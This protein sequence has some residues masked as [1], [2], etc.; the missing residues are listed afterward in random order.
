MKD[1]FLATLSHELRTPLNAILGWTQI[2]RRQS[3]KTADVE[4]GMEAIDRNARA[5]VMLIDELLDLSRII[6]GRIRLDMQRIRMSEVVHGA[7]ES[8]EPTAHTKGIR[9]ERGV[10]PVAAPVSGDPTR[11]QQVAWNL[12][13][14][15]IKFTPAGGTVRI[16]LKQVGS[17]VRL[18]V[19][20]TGIGISADFLPHVFDRFSQKDSSSTRTHGGLGL[21]LAISKQLVELHGGTL[22]AHS[23]GEGHGATFTVTLPRAALSEYNEPPWLQPSHA[24]IADPQGAL[25]SIEGARALV[26]DDEDDARDLVQRVLEE[27]GAIVTTTSS[28]EEAWALLAAI[29][30][31]IILCDIGM[32]GMDG[33]QLMRRIR[34][35]AGKSRRIPALALTAFARP[36][37]RKKAILAGYQSHLSKPFDIAELVIVVA[38]LLGRTG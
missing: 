35:G 3:I 18:T 29:D 19:S 32:P 16:E 34:S 21:G 2:L 7:I 24:A 6:S 30:I 25:P 38:G 5:Q 31:D 27:R 23:E 28:A 12:I 33:Y 20:D 4:R 8:I 11:L 15:A 1:E 37:D 22:T 9:L 26:I 36:E 14:N 10:D 17:E 13:S